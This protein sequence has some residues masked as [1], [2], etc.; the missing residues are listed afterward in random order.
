[1]R[2]AVVGVSGQLGATITRHFIDEGAQ[3]LPL[4]M[5]GWRNA[6]ARHLTA[7][8]PMLQTADAPDV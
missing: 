3:V 7:R 8:Q 4:T 1:M 6:L 2:V 5:P